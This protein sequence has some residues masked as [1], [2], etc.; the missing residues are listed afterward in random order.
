MSVMHF[1]CRIMHPEQAFLTR[2]S[3]I[4]VSNKAQ[5]SFFLHFFQ[6]YGNSAVLHE[7]IQTVA[8]KYSIS[9]DAFEESHRMKVNDYIRDYIIQVEEAWALDYIEYIKELL[10]SEEK[11]VACR[12]EYAKAH[13]KRWRSVSEY[14]AATWKAPRFLSHYLLDT[15]KEH[16]YNLKRIVALVIKF[17][18]E[19]RDFL[20]DNKLMPYY[21]NLY[22]HQWE[23]D[24]MQNYDLNMRYFESLKK[25]DFE[26]ALS[27]FQ[28]DYPQFS[29]IDDLRPYNDKSGAYVMILDKYKQMYVG[30]TTN[31][32][33]KRIQTH[34][35]KKPPFDRLI[36]G[37]VDNSILSIN[38]FRA[39]DTTRI[40][41]APIESEFSLSLLEEEITDTKY[42]QRFLLNRVTGGLSP[43]DGIGTTPKS[44]SLK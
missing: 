2:E 26:G 30:I 38:S 39:L 35:Q 12:K 3:F 25:E 4:D 28:A 1:G 32:L 34:W 5:N 11:M 22:F 43:V 33:K 29:F 27:R 15:S 42:L 6:R 23:V 14:E 13:N 40:M 31:S 16:Q 37:R 24:A 21:T 44:R 18:V 41:L 10:L 36:F 9:P 17:P 19:Y 20:I 8:E 7:A